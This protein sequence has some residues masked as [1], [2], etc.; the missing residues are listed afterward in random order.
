[1]KFII[2]KGS[3]HLNG[4]TNTLLAPFLD[5]LKKNGADFEEFNLYDM[6][7]EDCHACL[8]CQQDKTITGCVIQDDMQQILAAT[9]TADAIVV[10]SPI[11][12]WN[13]TAPTKAVLDRYVY[14]NCKFYGDDPHGPILWKGKTLYILT[15]CGYPVE[16]GTDL[17]E[18]GMKRYC[19]HC[20]LIYG[21]ML[22]ERQRNLKESFMSADKEEHAREFARKALEEIIQAVQ[23]KPL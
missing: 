2:L 15:T 18:E 21:G 14:A 6:K 19:K 16:K 22:A 1:M 10:A 23:I 9:L 4:N 12:V 3:P 8:A 13:C 20:G 7:I 17:F 11:Y 5:E